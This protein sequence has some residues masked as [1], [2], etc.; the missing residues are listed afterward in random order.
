M[1]DALSFR[2]MVVDNM[3]IIWP[4][5]ME[6]VREFAKHIACISTHYVMF[7]IAL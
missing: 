5:C 4:N 6:Y 3:D 7:I 2:L 1:E